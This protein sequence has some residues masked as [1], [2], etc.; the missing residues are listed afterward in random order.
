MTLL[1]TS[2]AIAA[3]TVLYDIP[4]AS[5]RL[6][7]GLMLLVA[8]T[9]LVGV[10]R[11]NN[12]WPLEPLLAVTLADL[13]VVGHLR[14]AAPTSGFGFVLILPVAW[15]AAHGGRHGGAFGA[16]A[17]L[18]VA[19]AP[20]PLLHLGISPGPV[21]LASVSATA[22]LSIVIVVLAAVLSAGAN[23]ESAQ[24]RLLDQQARHSEAAY[25]QARRDERVLAAVM[26]AVPFG[27]VSI[28]AEGSY[29]RSN[30]A[31]RAML[32]HLELPPGTPV[33]QLP[34]YHLDGTT[35][36]SDPD[37]PHIRGLLG[38]PIDA[39]VYWVGH[40]DR[41]RMAVEFGGRL[42]LND[43][44]STDQFV[45]VLRDVGESVEAEAARDQAIASVSHEFRTPLSSIL[46]FIEL[47]QD[48]P[49]LP[50]EAAEHLAIAER[51]ATRLLT[52]VSDLLATR[53]RASY[54]AVPLSLRRVDLNEVVHESV[55]ALRTMANDRLLTVTVDSEGA[56]PILGDDFRLRQVIDNLVSNA[57]K[58]NVDGGSIAVS[59]TC[60]DTSATLT[61]ADTGPGMT[62]RERSEVFEPY[63]RTSSAR[64]S[65]TPGTG[66]GLAICREIVTHHGGS[67]R[68]DEGE[69]GIGTMA[70]LQLPRYGEGSP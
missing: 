39:E 49:G 42:A 5:G 29:V 40:Q 13:L 10:V 16:I 68:L 34:L 69:D 38:E 37:K 32:R 63:H 55:T 46:G 65:S 53:Q 7:A 60:N 20:L 9:T 12:D 19:W 4:S 56:M 35:P 59:L 67:I 62:D 47:A 11:Q 27:V 2:A 44:G 52:L 22:S 6:T 51:N 14:V 23:R 54:H 58:Y 36:V 33:S 61:V 50:D 17:G 45:L 43:D 21:G 24:R 48:T 3:L 25:R 64:S 66:L 1:L 18:I 41:P 30:R 8:L 15:L 31:A 70:V 28:D 26:D 57:I